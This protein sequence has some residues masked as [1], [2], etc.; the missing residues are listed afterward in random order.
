MHIINVLM[1]GKTE[2][3][4]KWAVGTETEQGRKGSPGASMSCGSHRDP[5]MPAD[6]RGFFDVTN[7][8]W[9]ICKIDIDLT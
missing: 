8:V 9:Y 6:L 5:L 2:E 7:S 4:K 3:A 1:E